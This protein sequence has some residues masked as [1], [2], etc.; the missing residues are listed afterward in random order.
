MSDWN[1]W[2]RE[3]PDFRLGWKREKYL[4][5]IMESMNQ[6]EIIAL[7]G[8]RRSGKSTLM[9]Q[10]MRELV[11]SGVKKE[12]LLYLN[13]EDFR[14]INDLDVNLLESFYNAYR[15]EKNPEGRA[16]VF[17]DEIQNVPQWE[18][19]I[20]TY[21]EKGTD[22]KFVISGSSAALMSS[23]LATLLTGRNLTYTVYPFSFAEYLA[24]SGVKYEKA[25]DVEK[26][27]LAN[28]ERRPLIKKHL[29]DFMRF[30]G[31]P[32][33]IKTEKT[34]KKEELLQAYLEDIIRK[35][36]GERH[37]LR[38]IKN[39]FDIVGFVFSNA[40]RSFSGR[41]IAE[42]LEQAP[43]TVSDLVEYLEAANLFL[44]SRFF[45]HSGRKSINRRN[46]N[47]IYAQDTGF[48]R[49]ASKSWSEN[50]GNLYE[51][52]TAQHIFRKK[53]ELSYWKAID[54]QGKEKSEVDFVQKFGEAVIPVNV[55]S[56]DTINLRE[57]QGIADFCNQQK[58]GCKSGIIICHDL[59]SEETFEG[60][61]IKYYPLWAYLLAE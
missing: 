5:K 53:Q 46:P 43:K 15:E 17:F 32:A 2:D 54:S 47:K 14:L 7:Q 25:Q 39:V 48:I 23:E 9:F 41:K 50:L 22:V 12:Q 6:R 20:L 55:T 61:N 58:S 34:E 60:I 56:D 42:T 52:M 8:I 10:T 38:E 4:G 40:G 51:N 49:I 59:F 19:W 26:A 28:L 31:F 35:D 18:K 30:G 13:F 44:V 33:V 24:I 1:Y 36:V 45:S 3:I 27:Y 11:A 16:Y 57:K 37:Q 21:Y 29:D